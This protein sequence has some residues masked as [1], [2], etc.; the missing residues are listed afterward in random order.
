MSNSARAAAKGPALQVGS[1]KSL[2]GECTELKVIFVGKQPEFHE[3]YNNH[4]GPPWLCL[5]P[6]ST[7]VDIADALLDRDGNSH[8]QNS[9]RGKKCTRF[10]RWGPAKP[11]V[12]YR[13]KRG[14]VYRN[15]PPPVESRTG[16]AIPV[17]QHKT[18]QH[19]QTEVKN[20]LLDLVVNEPYS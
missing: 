2:S 9:T 3:D 1:Y 7:N 4:R 15:V 13:D 10:T 17:G 16:H 14:G 11:D 8:M 18:S 5:Q 12:D 19:G 20:T 6:S